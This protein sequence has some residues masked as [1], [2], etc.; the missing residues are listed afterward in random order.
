MKKWW[1]LSNKQTSQQFPCKIRKTIPT[2]IDLLIFW[3]KLKNSLVFLSLWCKK[4]SKCH[5][6]LPLQWMERCAI[7]VCLILILISHVLLSFL[8]LWIVLEIFCLVLFLIH[9]FDFGDWCS[10]FGVIYFASVSVESGDG[11]LSAGLVRGVDFLLGF[12]GF[13]SYFWELSRFLRKLPGKS[14]LRELLK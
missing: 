5:L 1:W 9:A 11:I 2:L 4:S 10:V 3:N 12:S 14:F 7:R 6:F 8:G 13:L